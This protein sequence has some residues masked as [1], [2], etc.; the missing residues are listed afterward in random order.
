M[1]SNKGFSLVELIVVIAIMAIIAAVAVPVY[2]TYITKAQN[3][4]DANTIAEVAHACKIATSLNGGTAKYSWNEGKTVLTVTFANAAAC[5]DAADVLTDIVGGYEA[6]TPATDVDFTVTFDAK[7]DDT[8]Q[9]VADALADFDGVFTPT[10]TP[11]QT[12]AQD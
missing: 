1:K 8:Y 11:A 3:G 4:S 10:Q 12:P 2:N 5:K 7:V 9:A 6:A